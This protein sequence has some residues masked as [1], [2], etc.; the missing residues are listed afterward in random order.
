M[1]VICGVIFLSFKS[2][3]IKQVAPAVVVSQQIFYRDSPISC[4]PS[5]YIHH[6]L[7]HVDSYAGN[8]LLSSISGHESCYW[9]ISFYVGQVDPVFTVR[10]INIVDLAVAPPEFVSEINGH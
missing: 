5:Q 4:F 1:L 2:F 3:Q 8:Q 7:G 6:K 9:P 10:Q